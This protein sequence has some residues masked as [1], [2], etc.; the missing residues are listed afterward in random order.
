MENVRPSEIRYSRETK[1]L[2][3]TFDDQSFEMSAEF[4]RVHSPSAEVR[5]HGPGQEVLQTG[6]E[7]VSIDAIEPV[8]N[9]AVRLCFDDG[10]SSGLYS[11][12][13][14][15]RLGSERDPLWSAYLHA[16]EEAG[17][18]RRSSR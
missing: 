11:F 12:Q 16:L 2:T 14:L 6:K 3:L 15:Y 17:V 1:V 10:H 9:Y 18:K 5:G 7:D 8:G 13:E 4:L